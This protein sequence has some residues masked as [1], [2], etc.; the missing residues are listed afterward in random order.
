MHLESAHEFIAVYIGKER[1]L[2]GSDAGDVRLESQ[3]LLLLNQ[4]HIVRTKLLL[5]SGLRMLAHPLL[6]KAAHSAQAPPGE[7]SLVIIPTR[8]WRGQHL[9]AREDGVGA[10]QEGESLLGLGEEMAPGSEADNGGGQDQASCCNSPQYGLEVDRL[11]CE[12]T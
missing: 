6:L 10:G 5:A 8:G 7:H 1:S 2:E 12:Q 11:Y 9:V 3:A 4:H